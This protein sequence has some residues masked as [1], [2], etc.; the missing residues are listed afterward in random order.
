MWN[1]LQSDR[2]HGSFKPITYCQKFQTDQN[3]YLQFTS[4][5]SANITLKIYQGLNEIDSK[6]E[7]FDSSYGS[8]DV[9][10]FTNFILNF[11]SSVSE[12]VTIKVTQGSSILTS[13]PVLISDLTEDITS[14]RI[15]YVKYTN[16]DR[17]ESD[18]DD[19]FIDWSALTSTGNYLDFFIEAQ[20]IE[21]SDSDSTEVLEGSQS[22]TILSANYYSGRTL[23]TGSIPD[24]LVTRLGMCS[25]LD[26]FMVNDI[27]YIKSGEIEVSNFGNSTL[28][29]AALKLTQKL[30][31]GINVD[32][33]GTLSPEPIPE[34]ELN[35]MFIGSVTDL[36]ATESD[37]KSMTSVLVE[38]Q[39]LI[40]DYTVSVKRYCFAYPESYGL[41]SLIK[42]NVTGLTITSGFEV[43][44]ATF[45][46]SS[47]SVLYRIYTLIRP[48]TTNDNAIAFRF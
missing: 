13:E 24:Y 42:D 33:L 15:K 19:R 5:S 46:I 3:I 30:T 39:D 41:L 40:F 27:Q 44:T 47:V 25:S 45:T 18:L 4:D 17:V 16:L 22:K 48:V 21:L 26:I 35:P 43:R 14:G 1:T 23:K 9:R 37:I 10:Y 6:T 11:D 7:S 29:Q 12:P 36:L 2:K 8:S 38:K 31:I 34:P 32:N 20:D 28:F